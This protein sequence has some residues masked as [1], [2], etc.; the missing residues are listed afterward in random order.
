MCTIIHA[1]DNNKS[2]HGKY[3]FVCSSHKLTLC[4]HKSSTCYQN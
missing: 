1:A 4:L 3:D 2:T